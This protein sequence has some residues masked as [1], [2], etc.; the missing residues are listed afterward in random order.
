M[1]FSK[2]SC[3]A[4]SASI[5]V[6]GPTRFNTKSGSLSLDIITNKPFLSPLREQKI[7]EVL[8]GI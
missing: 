3:E 6:A 7:L 5:S 4:I 8:K 2:M 1:L